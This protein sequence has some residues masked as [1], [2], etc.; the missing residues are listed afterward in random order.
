ER[1]KAHAGPKRSKDQTALQISDRGDWIHNAASKPGENQ[2]TDSRRI[3]SLND[4]AGA[5]AV[6]GED[7]F[8]FMTRGVFRRQGDEI[9]TMKIFWSDDILRLQVMAWWESQGR[10]NLGKF[11]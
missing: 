9:Q 1:A 2:S 8:S 7:G 10:W 5:D 11:D 3:C 6:L 4:D